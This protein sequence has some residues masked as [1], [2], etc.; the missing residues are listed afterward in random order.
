[1]LALVVPVSIQLV[2]TGSTGLK[3]P[4]SSPGS[5]EWIAGALLLIALGVGVAAPILALDDSVEPIDGLDGAAG[6]VIGI[7]LYALGLG[8]VVFSQQ[9]MGR[10]WRVGVDESERTELV[11]GGPFDFVRNPIFTGLLV[12]SVGFTLM[13]PSVVSFAST[14]LLLISLELQTRLVEEPYLT[15]VHGEAY[16]GWARRVGRFVPGVG[17]LAR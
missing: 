16:S 7:V 10:S 4:G 5:I 14:A 15:R 8:L 13:V 9:W 1:V 3:G 11:Q 17:R 6:H 12:M 2:R